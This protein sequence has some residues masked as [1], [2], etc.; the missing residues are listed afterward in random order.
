ME[1]RLRRG[2]ESK[3]E[4]FLVLL[5]SHLLAER[6]RIDVGSVVKNTSSSIG[7]FARVLWKV[8]L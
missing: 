5:P 6:G 2:Q 4:T 8:V 7:E 1:A 3:R